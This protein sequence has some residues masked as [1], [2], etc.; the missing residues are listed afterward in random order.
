[1]VGDGE[2]RH[3]EVGG[4]GDDLV[5]A[6]GAVAEGEV[7]VQMKVDEAHRGAGLFA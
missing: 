1:V 2:G 5:D 6:A 3:A 4:A 7:R